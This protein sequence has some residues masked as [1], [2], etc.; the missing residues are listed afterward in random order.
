M[1]ET[2]LPDFMRDLGE[3]GDAK[4]SLGLGKDIYDDSD[5]KKILLKCGIKSDNGFIYFNQLL[6]NCMKRKYGNFPI[7]RRM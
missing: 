1:K 4:T 7:G 3:I 6:Y 2:S 5:V